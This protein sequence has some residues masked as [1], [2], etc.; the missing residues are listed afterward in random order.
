M[1][2]PI[3]VG[4]NTP[5]RTGLFLIRAREVSAWS[6]SSR[7]LSVEIRQE[8]KCGQGGIYDTDHEALYKDREI[9]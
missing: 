6:I 5:A 2:A 7:T 4:C 8:A 1:V 3:V 9:S